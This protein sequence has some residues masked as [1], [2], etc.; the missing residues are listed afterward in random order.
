RRRKG[1]GCRDMIPATCARLLWYPTGSDR[2]GMRMLPV[3]AENNGRGVTYLRPGRI[4]AAVPQEGVEE[5]L[6]SAG[7]GEA[8]WTAAVVAGRLSGASRA[9]SKPLARTITPVPIRAASGL[10]MSAT[11]PRTSGPKI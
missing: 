1:L 2:S 8:P 6:C 9:K 4:L 3:V 7:A 11:K 5:P 10:A